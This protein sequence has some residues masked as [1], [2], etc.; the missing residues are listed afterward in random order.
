MIEQELLEI[1]LAAKAIE[2]RIEGMKAF[3]LIREHRGETLAYGEEHFFEVEKELMELH[4]RVVVHSHK[5]G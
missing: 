5:Y 1:Y 3:N 2:C 4:S